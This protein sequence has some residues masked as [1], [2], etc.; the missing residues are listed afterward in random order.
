MTHV[1]E[2]GFPPTKLMRLVEEIVCPHPIY[3][4]FWHMLIILYDKG[5]PYKDNQTYQNFFQ[6]HEYDARQ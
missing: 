3:S 6:L 4:G 2:Y 5:K 1:L